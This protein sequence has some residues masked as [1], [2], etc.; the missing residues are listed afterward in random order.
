MARDMAIELKP[1]NVASISLWQGLTFTEKFA[2]NV[3][4]NPELKDK[5]VTNPKHGCTPDY[6]GMVIAALAK[7]PNIMTKSGGT[8]ISAEVGEEYGVVDLNGGK[9]TSLRGTLNPPIFGPV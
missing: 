3:A 6:Q 8:Y 5:P 4:A 1:H 9:P 2:A 7:D